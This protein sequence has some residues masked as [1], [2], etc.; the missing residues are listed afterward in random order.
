MI[1]GSVI[2]YYKTSFLIAYNHF[3]NILRLFDI[4]IVFLSPQAKQSM[5]IS[6]KDGIYELPHKLPNQLRLRISEN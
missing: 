3:L 1:S 5:I 2:F 4:L 6:N